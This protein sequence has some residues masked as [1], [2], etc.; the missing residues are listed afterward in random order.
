MNDLDKWTKNLETINKILTSFSAIRDVRLDSERDAT[1]ER[2][3][4]ALL[5]E[6]SL[7]AIEERRDSEICSATNEDFL[8]T[9]LTSRVSCRNIQKHLKHRTFRGLWTYIFYRYVLQRVLQHQSNTSTFRS[10]TYK[11]TKCKLRIPYGQQELG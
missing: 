10:N 3:D 1:E 8:E 7:F 5:S 4:S 2:L 6:T 11:S 9:C